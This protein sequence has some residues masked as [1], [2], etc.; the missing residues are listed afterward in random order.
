MSEEEDYK[1]CISYQLCNT[2]VDLGFH[3]LIVSVFLFSASRPLRR[4]LHQESK[5]ISEL[6]T[7]A[8]IVSAFV[9]GNRK[10]PCWA[11]LNLYLLLDSLLCLQYL[12]LFG[13]NYS[14]P[15]KLMQGQ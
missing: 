14:L 8:A 5:A 2:L 13:M 7:F 6:E 10:N 12:V 11:S 9:T 3:K 15:V 4:P 1:G